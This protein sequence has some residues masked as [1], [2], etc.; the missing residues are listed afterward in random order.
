MFT[1]EYPYTDLNELNLDWLIA[2]VKELEER[3]KE[4]EDKANE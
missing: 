4:L 2:K 1:N 3:V